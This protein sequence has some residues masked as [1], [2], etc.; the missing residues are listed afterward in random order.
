MAITVKPPD[1]PEIIVFVVALETSNT[2][3]P[4]MAITDPALKNIQQKYKESVAK[5]IYTVFDGL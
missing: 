3:S 4:W 2:L 5:Q 1:A